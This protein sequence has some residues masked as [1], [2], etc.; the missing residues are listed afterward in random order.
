MLFLFIV[1][2]HSIWSTSKRT[3]HSETHKHLFDC[4]TSQSLLWIYLSTNEIMY[5]IAKK[6]K[7]PPNIPLCPSHCFL[8]Q[9]RLRLKL[10]TDT[11]YKSNL[12]L[13]AGNIH[14]RLCVRVCQQKR[15]VSGSS[16]GI[17]FTRRPLTG[18][19]GV[20]PEKQTND[21]Q[22]QSARWDEVLWNWNRSS[23]PLHAVQ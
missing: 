9:P 11:L 4:I 5:V 22:T 16:E 6:K 21:D 3:K 13:S 12:S 8:P 20:K 17:V 14:L 2:S 19:S 23:A 15:K 7:T 10:R 1:L 18:L